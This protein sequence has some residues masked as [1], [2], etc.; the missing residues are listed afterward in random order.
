MRTPPFPEPGLLA[1][2]ELGK[3]FYDCRGLHIIPPTAWRANG[4][5][6]PVALDRRLNVFQSADL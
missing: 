6:I 4:R 1:L 2:L 5:R 3:G